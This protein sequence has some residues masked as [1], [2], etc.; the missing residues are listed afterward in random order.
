MN[1]NHNPENLEY[2][3][4]LSELY[5]N[6]VAA[7]TEIINLAAKLNLPKGTE[8]FVSDIHGEYEAFDYVMRNASGVI[9]EY[10]EELFASTGMREN[11][12]KRLAMLI[13]YPE[14]VLEKARREER[15]KNDYYRSSLLRMVRVC[16]RAASKY[17]RT[18]V[19]SALPKEFAYILE[20]LLHEDADR[21]NKQEYYNEIIDRIINLGCS[22]D[23]IK[24]LASLI[25]R[26]AVDHLHVI[27]DIFDRGNGAEKVMDDLC[28]YHSVD[29]QWGNHDILWMGAASG[30][31]ACISNVIRISA[32]YN[33]LETL[34]EGYGIN[35]MPLAI[36]A[37][38]M[39]K[40]DPCEQFGL[41]L[42]KSKREGL[43]GKETALIARIQKAIS[44]IQ[45]KVEAGVIKRNPN[46]KMEDRMLLHKIDFNKGK[47]DIEG[48]SYPLLDNNFPTVDPADPYKLA[49][50]EI[51]VMEKLRMNFLNSGKLQEH[52]R[53][54]FNRGS[55]YKLHNKNLLFHGCVPMNTDGTL[56]K[57][58]FFEAPMSGRELFDE[59]DRL[60]RQGYARRGNESESSQTSGLDMMW[61]LWCGPNSPLFGKNKMATFERYFI[62]EKSTHVEHRDPYFTLRDQKDICIKILES[63]GLTDES[64]CIIN[65]HVPVKV[66]KGESPI[67]AKGKLLNIDGGFAKAY[68]KVTGL[69]GYTLTYNSQGM[70]IASHKPFTSALDV[71]NDEDY[72]FISRVYISQN[73]SR[74]RVSD[75]DMGETITKRIDDLHMLVDAYAHG[76]IKEV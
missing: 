19:R 7:C 35:L 66:K 45:F 51:V 26:L 47:I 65:G 5:P 39:Y 57:V 62:A 59:F 13:C 23:V 30:S 20:E 24:A 71:I 2:L 53:F 8:H 37:M 31:F 60:C 46:Y 22:E 17:S 48:K 44:I 58:R 41:D 40:D 36:F 25:L 73:K 54:L 42:E 43:K 74:I 52:V 33:T 4:L 38:E 14:L 68:Q 75:T 1:N 34:E 61:Y 32:R 15:D 67:K 12:K 50:E 28:N 64:S 70:A 6:L 76:L 72:E 16:K 18:K 55:M 29:V 9:W 63:F 56:K 69:A 11:D 21:L 3:K 27:G 49:P 10:I